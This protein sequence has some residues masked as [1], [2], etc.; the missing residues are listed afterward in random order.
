MNSFQAFAFPAR[1]TSHTRAE[2]F[3]LVDANSA[4]ALPATCAVSSL[5]PLGTQ[6]TSIASTSAGGCTRQ[7]WA[8]IDRIVCAIAAASFQARM[9]MLI[10]IDEREKGAEIAPAK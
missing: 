9:P 1:F 5:Q 10:R 7:L 2:I 3:P 4:N 8:I 6:T